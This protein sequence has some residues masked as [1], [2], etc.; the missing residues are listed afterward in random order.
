MLN[1]SPQHFASWDE[2]IE[3]LYACHGRVKN[4]CRQLQLL[5]DYVAQH[6]CNQAVQ[7][8]VKQILNYFNQAAPLHHDDEEQ[9]FFPALLQVQPTAQAAVDE[10][11]T[12]HHQLHD[13]WAQ[14]SVQLNELLNGTRANVERDLIAKFVAG[15]E[16]HIAIEEPLFELGRTHLATEALNAMG[17]VMAARRKA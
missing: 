7:N 1:L 10:L 16:Q 12:Q 6:G 9:D 13:N 17:K 4:F 2:P 3:M 11:T 15:Y 8:D 5:P 14:L